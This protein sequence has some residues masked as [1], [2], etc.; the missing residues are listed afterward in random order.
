MTFKNKYVFQLVL[1]LFLS[2]ESYFDDIKRTHFKEKRHK[3]L[4]SLLKT[5]HLFCSLTKSICKLGWVLRLSLNVY[6]S[7]INDLT[8]HFL[9]YYFKLY[10]EIL[11]GFVRGAI[12]LL[13]PIWRR[14]EEAIYFSELFC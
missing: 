4:L 2:L 5:F 1:H 10:I 13:L 6:H 8:K 11:S 12:C 7:C 3:V 9:Y 14:F